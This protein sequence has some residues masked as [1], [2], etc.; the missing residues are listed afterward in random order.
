MNAML[1]IACPSFCSKVI[2]IE[3]GVLPLLAEDLLNGLDS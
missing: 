3:I 2:G 1:D